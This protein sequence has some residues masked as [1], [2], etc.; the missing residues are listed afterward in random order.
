[1]TEKSNW[2][3]NSG[4]MELVKLNKTHKLGKEGYT[5]AWRFEGWDSRKCQYKLEAWLSDKFGKAYSKKGE[6]HWKA[7]HGAVKYVPSEWSAT[8]KDRKFVYWVAVK[9]PATVTFI[10]LQM[11]QILNETQ[12]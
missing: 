9:D 12:N 7:C 8:E 4:T 3:Y 5:Y 6:K 11:D 10:E 1:M 2:C